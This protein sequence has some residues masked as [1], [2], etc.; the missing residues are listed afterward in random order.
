V[1]TV[2]VLIGVVVAVGLVGSIIGVAVYE[3]QGGSVPFDVTF[4]S[5]TL[6]LPAET[7]SQTSNGQTDIEVPIQRSNLTTVSFTVTVTGDAAAR[8]APRMVD[9]EVTPPE[10]SN[11]SS[12][13][14]SGT[15][16]SPSG[17][18]VALDFE[19]RLASVPAAMEMSGDSID[20]VRQRVNEANS[21][22]RG[23]GTWTVTITV[24]TADP[25]TGPTENYTMRVEPATSWY[26]ADVTPQTPD[27]TR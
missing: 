21:T 26:S 8:T 4:T 7:A 1:Q 13:E 23:V 15:L 11:A 16:P 24:A 17:G 22:T 10:G 27:V 5:S 19:F 20:E 25:L 12:Q 18:S 14:R 9:V 2:D 6:D 3:E